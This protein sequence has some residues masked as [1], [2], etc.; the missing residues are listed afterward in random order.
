MGRT[1]LSIVSDTSSALDTHGA[2][3]GVFMR[4]RIAEV[5]EDVRDLLVAAEHDQGD[6]PVQVGG[7]GVARVRAH[8]AVQA[9]I[10][11]LPGWLPR[12]RGTTVSEM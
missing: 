6:V 10:W 12:I 3:R 1:V 11:R 4:D 5:G 2:F 9:R 8:P 7:E